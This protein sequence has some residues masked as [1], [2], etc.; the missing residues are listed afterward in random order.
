MIRETSAN[1]LI[2]GFKR[3]DLVKVT[4]Q[5]SI[6]DGGD[7]DYWSRDGDE[8]EALST[9]T[10]LYTPEVGPGTVN[11]NSTLPCEFAAIHDCGQSFELT[12]VDNWIEHSV[13]QHLK[14][15]L[16]ARCVCWFCD[17][18]VFDSEDDSSR[19]IN[20]ERRMSHISHHILEDRYTIYDIR[21]DYYM[22]R[23][24]YKHSLVDKTVY[25]AYRK[26][27]EIPTPCEIRP[28]NFIPP[29]AK[30]QDLLSKATIIEHANADKV[31]QRRITYL[32]DETVRIKDYDKE[33]QKT[34]ARKSCLASG[35]CSRSKPQ[36]LDSNK[37]LQS[38]VNIQRYSKTD[39]SNVIESIGSISAASKQAIPTVGNKIEHRVSRKNG[40]S[41][42]L[43]SKFHAHSTPIKSL[44]YRPTTRNEYGKGTLETMLNAVNDDNRDPRIIYGPPINIRQTEISRPYSR[45][46]VRRATSPRETSG[47]KIGREEKYQSN[48]FSMALLQLNI[49]FS[50]TN[51]QFRRLFW[52][53]QP[54]HLERRCGQPLY[55]DVCPTEKQQAIEYAQAASGSASSITVSGASASEKSPT[56]TPNS[57]SSPTQSGQN[58]SNTTGPPLSQG[59]PSSTFAPPVLP[60][61]TKKYLLLCVNTGRFE[62]KLEQIDL[63][64]I[65][66]D[67]AMFTLIRERY[68]SMRGPRLKRIFTVPKTVEFIKFELVRRSNT[69]EC[70]GNYEKNS[71]PGE[72][73]V[74]KREYTFSPCPPRIGTMPIHPHVFMHSLLN[75]GDHLGELAVLQLPKKVGRRLKCVAQ[76][77]DPFDVPYGWGIYI[78]EG[79]HTTLVSL[80]LLIIVGAMTLIVMLWSALRKDVQGGTG[81]GQYGLAA[82][83]MIV[84]ICA[85]SREQLKGL[86]R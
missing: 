58:V 4:P 53:R 33:T 45:V 10:D 36:H 63:T 67:V 57:L 44:R 5:T 23:H 79:L 60:R 31:R 77:R 62:I 76:P 21:V 65:V 46:S 40:T 42:P 11:S 85:F 68:E 59:Q 43:N 74:A 12:A 15:Y 30:R 49:L 55:M 13:S 84:A 1:E 17:E 86:A 61:G 41:D 38:K 47:R 29:E 22:L 78:V 24:L 64:N 6:F 75:P 3:E 54:S 73:E 34:D 51:I 52:P 48:L 8:S 20:F 80:L 72:K 18:F 71:I 25:A 35:A 26:H 69:G 32:E 19:R 39:E 83:G 9:S 82:V 28:F 7:T 14:G 81:I 66:L 27:T 56:Q 16:P 37:E 70:V 2:L 50:K